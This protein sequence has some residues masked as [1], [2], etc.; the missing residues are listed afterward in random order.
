MAGTNSRASMIAHSIWALLMDV[1]QDKG[2]Q[3]RRGP[4]IGLRQAFRLCQMPEHKRISFV[5]EGLPVIFDSAMG[6]WKAAQQLQDG[7]REAM[8]LEGFA[9]E[10]AAKILILMDSVRCP[11]QLVA[12]KLSKLIGWYYDHLA[13]LIYARAVTWRPQDLAQLRV[14]VDQRRRG[15]YVDGYAGEYIIPNWDVYERESRLYADV[16]AYQDGSI[17][18]TKPHDTSLG[19]ISF[20]DHSPPVLRVAEAMQQL[21][22]FSPKGL[23]AISQ[24]WGALEFRDKENCDDA[25]RLTEQLLKRL[26]NEELMQDTAQEV[27]VQNL[28]NTWQLPMYN[29]EFILIPVT[30]SELEMEQ[31]REY[32]SIIGYIE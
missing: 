9:E 1:E 31:E 16:E 32:R 22:L 28:Y 29:L 6:L 10:E 19:T 30:L 25:E 3:K 13:R 27:H 20:L 14:Y 24:I 7:S 23:Q 26:H 2:R 12:S 17:G 4:D 15:H 21:G 5:A 8:V 18:W 11:P